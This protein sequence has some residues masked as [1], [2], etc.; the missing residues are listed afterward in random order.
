MDSPIH[1]EATLTNTGILI[2]PICI[3]KIRAFDVPR[4]LERAVL[5]IRTKIALDIRS[6]LREILIYGGAVYKTK[7]RRAGNV[8]RI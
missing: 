4:Q 2:I 5:D 7:P 6:V 1:L 8:L 3:R